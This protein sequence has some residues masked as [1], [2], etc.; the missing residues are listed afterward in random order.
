MSC[1]RMSDY[2][3]ARHWVEISA[4]LEERR[5]RRKDLIDSVVTRAELDYR[6]ENNK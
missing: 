1:L 4:E 2:M 3:L 5:A 6:K